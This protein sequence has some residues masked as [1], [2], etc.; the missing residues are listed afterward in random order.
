M[1]VSRSVT[2]QARRDQ[3]VAAAIDLVAEQGYAACTFARIA[4]AAGLSS[5]R[6]ISYHFA[7]KDDLVE[8]V[9]GRVYAVIGDFLGK[10]LTDLADPREALASYIRST[11][12]LNDTHRAEMRVLTELVL[13]HGHESDAEV[14]D[15]RQEDTAVGRVEQVLRDGQA[16]GIFGDFDPTVT[17]TAVQR[18][19]ESIAFQLR[20]R[21]DTDLD[22]YAEELVG[23]FDRA[24]R[25]A[26][27]PH[28]RNA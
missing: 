10:R 16:T 1:Q 5:T 23:L 20:M 8:A 6:M 18:S 26:P 9:L 15:A 13:H 2:N 27:T 19:L 3:I 11:V 7:D 25:P 21:P 24:T 14:Y 28:R 12:A 22:H 17:A 4:K